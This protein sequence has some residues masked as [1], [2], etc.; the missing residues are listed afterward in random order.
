MKEFLPLIAAIG[1]GVPLACRMELTWIGS[2]MFCGGLCD[3]FIM[4]GGH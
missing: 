1:I 4:I 2:A 3:L